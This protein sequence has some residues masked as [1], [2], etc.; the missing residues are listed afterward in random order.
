MTGT[1]VRRPVRVLFD[2]G[3]AGIKEGCVVSVTPTQ[4]TVV[5]PS[6]T[7]TAG[8]TLDATI[9]ARSLSD[10]FGLS[11]ELNRRNGRYSAWAL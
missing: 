7:L 6:I 4:I 8:Q 5:T 10:C 9:T 1:K 11:L 2:I 3:T